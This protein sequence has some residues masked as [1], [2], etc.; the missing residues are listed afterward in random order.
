M[1][2]VAGDGALQ[3]LQVTLKG[4]QQCMPFSIHQVSVTTSTELHERF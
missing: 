1:D 3:E 4:I 2:D